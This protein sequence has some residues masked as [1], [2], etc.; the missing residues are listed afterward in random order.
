LVP[1][2]VE[3][4]EEE[5]GAADV[6]EV[7][8]TTSVA[9]Q[10]AAEEV[11]VWRE[12]AEQQA[13]S[14]TVEQQ[15]AL[16]IPSSP[17][18]T[19]LHP[20]V[21]P[22]RPPPPPAPPPPLNTA[23]PLD[24][25]PSPLAFPPAPTLARLTLTRA[26]G[27]AATPPADDGRVA[28][29]VAIHAA[30]KPSLAVSAMVFKWFVS[31]DSSLLS[32]EVRLS[33]GGG[34]STTQATYRVVFTPPAAGTYYVAARLE[35]TSRERALMDPTCSPGG[36]VNCFNI[37]GDKRP[38]PYRG[39]QLDGS[40]LTV[41]VTQDQL[42]SAERPWCH[43]SLHRGVWKDPS[44][45]QETPGSASESQLTAAFLPKADF[46]DSSQRSCQVCKGLD[47]Q[48]LSPNDRERIHFLC[49]R[50]EGGLRLQHTELTLYD[51]QR[52]RYCRFD[53]PQAVR[54]LRRKRITFVGDSVTMDL[55]KYDVPLCPE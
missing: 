43:G 22:R 47:E 2:T 30:Q 3:R 55:C 44:A 32:P 28:V 23:P 46:A 35:Y 5:E 14:L 45:G 31:S 39:V 50:K 17:P 1:E 33:D 8:A 53:R 15:P 51:G 37:G 29:T 41:A 9:T 26:T 25:P 18:S 52:C 13:I 6:V 49:R 16:L 27:V 20:A 24:V 11:V 19:P 4:V 12:E 38:E 48:K 36:D 42:S 54:C 40:P 7:A 10:A 34:A 21:S